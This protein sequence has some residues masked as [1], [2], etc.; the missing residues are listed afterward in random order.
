MITYTLGG[1]VAAI[2]LYVLFNLN[3]ISQAVDVAFS[4]FGQ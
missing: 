3:W 2:V 4:T 1:I